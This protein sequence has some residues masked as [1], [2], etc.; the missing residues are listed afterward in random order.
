MGLY[1]RQD[2]EQSELQKKVA[3]DLLARQQA[4]S[5]PEGD[6]QE[7]INNMDG[8][9]DQAFLEGQ[10]KDSK[11]AVFII[12]FIGI[13]VTALAYYAVTNMVN[14]QFKL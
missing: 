6:K 9:E 1:L 10:Q 14:S 4:N 8:Y 5:R 11:T 12:V 7:L 3:A 2:D 13:V